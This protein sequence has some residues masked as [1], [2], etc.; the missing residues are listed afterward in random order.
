MRRRENHPEIPQYPVAAEPPC[1]TDRA[2][3]ANA[4]NLPL[5]HRW[6]HGFVRVKNRTLVERD[7]LKGNSI[8]YHALQPQISHTH[9]PPYLTSHPNIAQLKPHV[10]FIIHKN[11][12]PKGKPR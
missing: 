11:K 12:D 10:E 2:R 1:R 7:C 4:D 9:P 8:Q 5:K 3:E 6:V